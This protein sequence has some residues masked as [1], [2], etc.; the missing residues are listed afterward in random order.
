MRILTETR[1]GRK[2]RRVRI[3]R[4]MKLPLF[5][6]AAE[7][8]T[9][10]APSVPVYCLNSTAL[11][12][13]ARQF[14]Q[15]FPGRVLYAVKCNPHPAVL[16]R[17]YAAGVRDF[18]TASLTE[19]ATVAEGLP[20]ASAY[21]MHPVKTR[22]ALRHAYGVY[23]VRHFVADHATELAKLLDELPA[24]DYAV[25]VRV[26][27]ASAADSVYDLSSKFGCDPAE[28]VVLLREIAAARLRPGLAFH[29]GSQ[30]RNPAAF[31]AGLALLETIADR[32]GVRPAV[33]DVGGGF[34]VDYGDVPVPP[35][36]TFLSAIRVGTQTLRARGDVELWCEPGRALVADT[37]SLIVQVQ[38]RKDDRLYLND[39]IF[40]SLAEMMLSNLRMPV[41]LLREA[42]TVTGASRAFRLFG[43]T[44]DSVDVVPGTFAL[45]ADVREGDWLEV[46]HLGAYAQA[47]ASRFNGFY[48]ETM[49]EVRH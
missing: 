6:S 19:I 12:R 43:P 45:P 31:A 24:R 33:V 4:A 8:V 28:A 49:V 20:A 13:N 46:S 3:L 44:C 1:C 39:G 2:G 25:L 29:V 7:V 47:L 5:D 48:P 26:G 22:A 27:T 30:C 15:G 16:Q 41:R 10:L 32:A 34:P 38:L 18:D 17:L 11:A 36:A 21:F 35:L 37:C 9:T 40:G 23:G 14:L 42:G